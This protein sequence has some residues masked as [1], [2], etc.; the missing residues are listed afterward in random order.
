MHTL[1]SS[2]RS[3]FWVYSRT[4]ASPRCLTCSTMG[5]TCVQSANACLA[6]VFDI[7]LSVWKGCVFMNLSGI[8][9]HVLAGWVCM[10]FKIVHVCRVMLPRSLRH[11]CHTIVADFYYFHVLHRACIHAFITQACGDASMH[12]QDGNFGARIPVWHCQHDSTQPVHLL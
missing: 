3:N 1:S 10:R 11:R 5:D 6:H 4:A 7:Y 2:T 8:P 9:V 12:S